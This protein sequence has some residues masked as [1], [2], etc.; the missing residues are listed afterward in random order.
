VVSQF[1][2]FCESCDGRE[3]F[4]A[5]FITCRIS[6]IFH[7]YGIAH[8][9]VKTFLIK[10]PSKVMHIWCYSNLHYTVSQVESFTTVIQWS[11][12]HH[13]F[14]LFLLTFVRFGVNLLRYGD[15]TVKVWWG[16]VHKSFSV[17]VAKEWI[18]LGHRLQG[19]VISRY[20]QLNNVRWQHS[21]TQLT[22]D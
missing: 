10:L 2:E 12:S 5:L 20:S 13:L 7:S 6:S 11:I 9:P 8:I 18:K 19:L 17:T 16:L 15:N 21:W 22:N 4:T 14:T 3:K 1:R